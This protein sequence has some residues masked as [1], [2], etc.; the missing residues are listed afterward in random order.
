MYTGV[1]LLDILKG[2]V[3]ETWKKV[4]YIWPDI[5]LE[6]NDMAGR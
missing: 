3:K 5:R 1:T 6:N 4:N 2:D